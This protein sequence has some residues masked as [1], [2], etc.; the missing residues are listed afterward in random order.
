MGMVG[1]I[2]LTYNYWDD[3]IKNN[4]RLQESIKLITDLIESDIKITKESIFS[5]Y[6]K[7]LDYIRFY[8][9]KSYKRIIAKL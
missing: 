5:R 1:W 2:H 4:K 7:H 9:R 6:Q 3:K 8:D